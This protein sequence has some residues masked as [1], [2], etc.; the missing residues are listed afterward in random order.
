MVPKA[1]AANEAQGSM[2]Q[3][4]LNRVRSQAVK[5]LCKGKIACP[6]VTQISMAIAP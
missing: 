1:E 2:D 4:G 3:S 5:S 6:K